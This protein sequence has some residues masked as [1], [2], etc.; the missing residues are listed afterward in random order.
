[1]GTTTKVLK[2]LDGIK[3]SLANSAAK[4]PAA[5]QIRALAPALDGLAGAARNTHM[6]LNDVE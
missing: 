3:F 1:M 4:L 5:V 2:N 6:M